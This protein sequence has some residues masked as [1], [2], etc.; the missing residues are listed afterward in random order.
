MPILAGLAEGARATSLSAARVNLA[1]P[2]VVV[3]SG[4]VFVGSAKSG[5]TA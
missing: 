5:K 4:A 3:E 1:R 2:N